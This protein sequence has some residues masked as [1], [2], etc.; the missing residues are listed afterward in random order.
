MQIDW[1]HNSVK[2]QWVGRS[3]WPRGSSVHTEWRRVTPDH[4]VWLVVSGSG[5]IR[6]RAG[7][8]PLMPG[9]AYWLT[10]GHYYD[11]EQDPDN[12]IEQYWMH[13]DLIDRGG[14]K[15]PYD[16]LRPDEMIP[17]ARAAELE[18][19]FIRIIELHDKQSRSIERVGEQNLLASLYATTLLAELDSETSSPLPE[20]LAGTIRYQHDAILALADRICDDPLRTPDVQAMADELGYSRDYFTRLFARITGQTPHAYVLTRKIINAEQLLRETELNVKQIA[21]AIAYPDVATFCR[22]FKKKVGLTPTAYRRQLNV[23]ASAK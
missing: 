8:Q 19:L 20:K 12:P 5:K 18:R 6:L 16:A 21:M 1:S 9:H 14:M 11:I 7:W 17:T 3:E 13:F 22:Q 10:P 4:D 23:K 15:R 2:I